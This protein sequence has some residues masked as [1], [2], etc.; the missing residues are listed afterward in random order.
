MTES[1]T[2]SPEEEPEKYE[3]YPEDESV[4]NAEIYR[5]EPYT[6]DRVMRIL[7]GICGIVIALFLLNLLKGALLPFFVAFVIAYMLEPIVR[8]NMRWTHL[9]HRFIPVVLTLIEVCSVIGVF[10]VLFIPYLINET[11]SMADTLQKYATSKIQ[12]PL[13]SENIHQFIRD[14]I[15]FNSV[16]KFFSHAE[17]GNLIKQA[18]KQSWSFLSS[19]IN[20][21][22]AIVSWLIVVLYLIF[23]MIDY[24]RL[25]ITFRQMIPVR[26]RRRVFRI[27]DD[28]K[29][30]M[31]RY[32]RGQFAI[33][34]TVG[35]LFAIGFYFIGLPMGVVLG[36]FIGILNMVPYLQLISLPITAILCIVCTASTGADF[37]VIFWECMG[38]YVVVQC[39]QDLILTPKIMG[40]SMGLNP[41]IILLSLSVWGSLFGFMGLI[42][43]L[44][45][46][47]L[48]L[49]YYNM[50]VIQRIQRKKEFW[51]EKSICEIDEKDL[52]SR[53]KC[54]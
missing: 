45:L 30:A 27:L 4:D 8:W 14:N 18:L 22:I 25:G 39:I 28:I 38:L 6:F 52:S 19:G 40:K 16:S 41:A 26:H 35:I 53:H 44:P 51:R 23:I 50:Y 48:L 49:S 36:L 29:D 5:R 1:N 21:I 12:I 2:R 47:T 9:R 11:G 13:I 43:A 37:W 20:L 3:Q 24:D 42:I 33:A 34:F 7:F 10:L 46:T 15:D 31:N 54:D 17:W 32:F